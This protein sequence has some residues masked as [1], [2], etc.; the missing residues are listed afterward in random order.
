MAEEDIAKL[1]YEVVKHYQLPVM[2][3]TVLNKKIKDLEREIGNAHAAHYLKAMVRRDMRREHFDFQPSINQGIDIYAKRVQYEAFFR[4]TE[5]RKTY[6]APTPEAA[7]AA[8][9][10]RLNQ[11]D[12]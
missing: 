3:H 1:Y 10:E 9:A 4:R 8:E 6:K 2:N 7:A 12:K 11:W 5:P